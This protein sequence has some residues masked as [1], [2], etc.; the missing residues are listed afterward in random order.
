MSSRTEQ[1]AQTHEQI[2]QS[3]VLLLKSRGTMGT[4]IPDVMSQTGLTV[5]GFYSHFPSKD[6]MVEEALGQALEQR[7]LMFQEKVK[8]NRW[9]DRIEYMLR[10][11]LTR[12]HRDDVAG[13]CPI[14]AV[15][16]DI[17]RDGVGHQALAREVEA[18]LKALEHRTG[19][20]LNRS[21]RDAAIGALTLMIGSLMMSRALRGTTLADEILRASRRFGEQA[22][23][24]MDRSL[25]K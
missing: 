10:R 16:S 24:A 20:R 6:A 11:Y 14:P 12:K 17:A 13:G 3:A 7:L 2:L 5:G 4:T 15:L 19:D 1:K 22:L 18:I 9:R 25:P 21:A 23:Q 8:A